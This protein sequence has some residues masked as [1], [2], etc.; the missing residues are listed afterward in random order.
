MN[1]ETAYPQAGKEQA[2]LTAPSR[3]F[4][5]ARPDGQGIKN[6]EFSK[7]LTSS[8]FIPCSSVHH[9]TVCLFIIQFSFH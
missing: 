8:F 7:N 9:S 2:R 5:G 6:A 4:S 3:S 1:I